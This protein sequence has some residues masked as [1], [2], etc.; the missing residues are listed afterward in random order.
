MSDLQR[1]LLGKSIPRGLPP[2]PGLGSGARGGRSRGGY[3]GKRSYT[4]VSWRK[5]WRRKEIV[6]TEAG[7]FCVY[8]GGSESSSVS[9]CLLHGAGY[10]GLTWSVMAE[11]L[12]TLADC[13][14][15]ALDLRGHGETEARIKT[16]KRVVG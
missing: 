2:R 10:S 15:L 13:R 8:H 1:K 7:N 4:G 12:A 9:V 6:Q 3:G 5:Y 14:L 16:Y 11:H